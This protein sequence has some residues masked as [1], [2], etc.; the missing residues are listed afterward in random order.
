[1]PGRRP[2]RPEAGTD[3]LAALGALPERQRTAVALRYLA[4]L[5]YAE[6]ARA[7]GWPEATCRTLA[8]GGSGGF[9]S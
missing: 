5:P 8:R 1:M 3:A 6:V 7:T 4:D 2:G 9:G